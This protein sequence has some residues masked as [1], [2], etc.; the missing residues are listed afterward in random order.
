MVTFTSSEKSGCVSSYILTSGT[1]SL[2]IDVPMAVSDARGLAD[3]IVKLNRHV[4]ALLILDSDPYHYLGASE[5][6]KRF[7]D[8][9]IISTSAVSLDIARFGRTASTQFKDKLGNEMPAQLLLPDSLVSGEVT[10]GY[11]TLA[12]RSFTN[13]Q[14]DTKTILYEPKQKMLF[15]GDLVYGKVHP[16]LAN[17]NINEWMKQLQEAKKYDLLQVYPG[18]GYPGDKF[19]IDENMNYIETFKRSLLTNDPFA[20]RDI[21][22][23]YFKGY[24]M[25]QFLKASIVKFLGKGY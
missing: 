17:I 2:L 3:T 24:K 13:G 25:P 5:I 1:S 20:V 15:A 14:G 12:I 16:D 8:I 9:K 21:V 6:K 19:I 22:N 4:K 18:H 11:Y 10:L 23:S 7:P